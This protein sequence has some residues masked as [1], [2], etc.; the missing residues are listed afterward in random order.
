MSWSIIKNF[1]LLHSLFQKFII[2]LIELSLCFQIIRFFR[3]WRRESAIR[4]PSTSWRSRSNDSPRRKTGEREKETREHRGKRKIWIIGAML[5]ISMIKRNWR[6]EENK[7]KKKAKGEKS[8]SI[9]AESS[10]TLFPSFKVFQPWN[11]SQ[12]KSCWI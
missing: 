6:K 10:S 3:F 4:W 7:T 11:S 5:K 2:T 8:K 1:F 12:C 9:P